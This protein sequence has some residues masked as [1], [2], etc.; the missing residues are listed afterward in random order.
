MTISFSLDEIEKAA[1][2]FLE[3]VGDAKLF[4]FHGDMGAGK[5]TFIHALC[6][7]LKVVDSV[8]SPT[9]SIINEFY[10]YFY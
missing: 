6:T 7:K 8:S 10:F 1:T 9:F 4:A 5:T 2:D 3:A